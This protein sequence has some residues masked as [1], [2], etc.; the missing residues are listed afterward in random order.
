MSSYS[1]FNEDKKRFDNWRK[2]LL[3]EVEGETSEISSDFDPDATITPEQL[4]AQEDWLLKVAEEKDAEYD[5]SIKTAQTVG[6]LIDWYRIYGGLDADGKLKSVLKQMQGAAKEP[7]TKEWVIQKLGKYAKPVLEQL[8]TAKGIAILT[9]GSI[10]SALVTTLLAPGAGAATVLAFV[11]KLLYNAGI[12]SASGLALSGA[13]EMAGDA[14]TR[15]LT[16]ENVLKQLT[17]IPDTEDGKAVDPPIASVF[18]IDDDYLILAKKLQEKG[19]D[20]QKAAIEAFSKEFKEQYLSIKDNPDEMNVWMNQSLREFSEQL[21]VDD[22]LKEVLQKALL[23][24]TDKMGPD[25]ESIT[26]K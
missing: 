6:D 11:G 25:Y 17:E 20:V 15:I 3:K 9:T 23:M 22:K 18:D 19:L 12:A 24:D 4:K 10:A 5:G 26:G 16:D 14:M 13:G 7:I 1:S 8:T 21:N 2:F